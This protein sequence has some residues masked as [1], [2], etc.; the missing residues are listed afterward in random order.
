MQNVPLNAPELAIGAA[1]LLYILW[2]RSSSRG[3]RRDRRMYRAMMRM[4]RMAG[5][6]S[7]KEQAKTRE[8]RERSAVKWFCA[9]VALCAATFG[10]GVWLKYQNLTTYGL[11]GLAVLTAGWWTWYLTS[12]HNHTVVIP[13]YEAMA[14]YTGWDPDDRADKWLKVPRR[15]A[16]TGPPAFVLWCLTVGEKSRFTPRWLKRLRTAV[17]PAVGRLWPV[18]GATVRV[19][20]PRA[21]TGSS[22]QTAKIGELVSRRL[23]GDWS[24][25]YDFRKFR[26]TFKVRKPL[27]TMLAFDIGAK[28][29]MHKIPLGV[30]AEDKWFRSDETDVA[31]HGM[32]SA[33]TGFGKT[34]IL[35]IP[36]AW[37]LYH[38]GFVYWGDVK[39]SRSLMQ[40]KGAPGLS[41]AMDVENIAEMIHEFYVSMNSYYEAQANGEDIT[42]ETKWP[43]K[44]LVLDE[45]PSLREMLRMWWKVKNQGKRAG[46]PP[47]FNELKMI[48]T[49]GREANHRVWAGVQQA[50][51]D[52]MGTSLER[53]MYA[54]KI[55]AGPQSNESWRMMFGGRRETVA[56]V[57]GR[58]ILG[59]GP[60][61][62]VIQLAR[63][64]ENQFRGMASQ[65]EIIR[66]ERLRSTVADHVPVVPPRPTY[67][68]HAAETAVGV[69]GQ[70]PVSP[71]P[72]LR[73]VKDETP[74]DQGV[75]AE[76]PTSE[77]VPGQV[78]PALIVGIKAG[79]EFL[80][81]TESAFERARKR[82]TIDGETRDGRSPAW[83]PQQ[84][85]EWH[86]Q[87]PIA[88]SRDLPPTATG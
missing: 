76:N 78:D 24:A 73:L 47:A 20:F 31:P 18:G 6:E 52:V 74:S 58:A 27:P 70:S 22:E 79:A 86:A 60:T 1:I 67:A 15:A 65:G 43:S 84:L 2:P 49:Q 63:I 77:D 42:D 61:K 44:L 28:P 14:S 32:V 30:I 13:L 36:A 45:L 55:A 33:S 9:S 41:I 87:R 83:T 5:P 64:T 23:P 56:L 50:S 81:M 75:Y 68:P 40:I 62:H 51:K 72:R 7:V 37:T 12:R 69:P 80:G 16:R 3:N 29:E 48:L 53:D 39:R 8:E 38:G 57:K 88:G 66:A 10:V 25:T 4:S 46:D 17:T 59:Y 35:M 85:R 11:E 54:C 19:K 26:A 21:W 82:A 34:T 71:T